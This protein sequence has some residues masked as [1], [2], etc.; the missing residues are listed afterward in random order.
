MR[1]ELIF[2]AQVQVENRYL[3]CRLSSM[4]SRSFHRNGVAIH[5]T[6]NKVLLLI[7]GQ[8][9]LTETTV[10]DKNSG[11]ASAYLEKRLAAICA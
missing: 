4:S 3:L 9:G 8:A 7:S 5:E 11:A 1:S 10:L 2:A 6:I